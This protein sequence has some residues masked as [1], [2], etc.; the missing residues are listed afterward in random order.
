MWTDGDRLRQGSTRDQEGLPGTPVL[1]LSRRGAEQPAEGPFPGRALP[2]HFS[3]RQ[4]CSQRARR[5]LWSRNHCAL[6]LER[7]SV[8]FWS[9]GF[10][11]K[12]FKADNLKHKRK[13]KKPCAKY[14]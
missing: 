9:S 1:G 2:D 5:D 12:V 7:I 4:Y 14:Q 6:D 8:I 13:E 10:F 3:G 11:K